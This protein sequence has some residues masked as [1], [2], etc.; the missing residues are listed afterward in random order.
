MSGSHFKQTISV[1]TAQTRNV[2]PHSSNCCR[3]KLPDE[4]VVDLGY[5]SRHRSC[6][7]FVDSRSLRTNRIVPLIQF[8]RSGHRSFLQLSES[9][10]RQCLPGCSSFRSKAA[11]SSQRPANRPRAVVG[12]EVSSASCMFGSPYISFVATQ[13]WRINS[14]TSSSRPASF[15]TVRSQIATSSSSDC[16]AIA[17]SFHATVVAESYHNHVKDFIN[18]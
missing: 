11:C 1:S 9:T 16:S 5:A 12:D 2:T 3:W 10:R 8:A 13:A 7:D 4:Y 6:N 14:R 15:E 18:R 17:R